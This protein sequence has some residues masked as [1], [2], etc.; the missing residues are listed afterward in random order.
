MNKLIILNIII[1]SC[2]FNAFS[3][4]FQIITSNLAKKMMSEQKPVLIK[5]ITH[6]NSSVFKVQSKKF[7]VFSPES[8]YSILF[9]SL[10]N[11][12][13]IEKIKSFPINF[14]TDDIR[15]REQNLISNIPD[16]IDN[17]IKDLGEKFNLKL[18]YKDI[19]LLDSLDKKIEKIGIENLTERDIFIISLYLDEFFRNN[20]EDTFWAIEKI[21]TLNTYWIP[22]LKRKDSKE[23]YSFYRT[24]FKSY[25]ENESGLLNLKLNY[26]LKLADYKGYPILSEE[27]I[28]FIKSFQ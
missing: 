23:E 11:L 20:T 27:H 18:N 22:Y 6:N 4:D 21:F 15:E 14:E 24:I 26:L 12:D 8:K 17:Y 19:H 9:N 10:E 28:N 5:K 7:I 3:Q 13:T 16:Q 1:M 2:T 25:I